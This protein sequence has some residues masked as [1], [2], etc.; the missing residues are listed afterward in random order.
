MYY[1]L[2]KRLKEKIEKEAAFVEEFGEDA[3]KV[4]NSLK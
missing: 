4:V 3:L 1:D 2:E